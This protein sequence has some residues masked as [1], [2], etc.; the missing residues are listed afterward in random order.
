MQMRHSEYLQKNYINL[1]EIF[2]HREIQNQA[3]AG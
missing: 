2:T 1:M 3:K